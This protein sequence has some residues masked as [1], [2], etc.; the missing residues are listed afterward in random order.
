MSLE[1]LGNVS[2]GPSP[3]YHETGSL[4]EDPRPS[5]KCR[6]FESDIYLL[7][8]SKTSEYCFLGF[9]ALNYIIGEKVVNSIHL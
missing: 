1:E 6:V 5:F 3:K 2:L 4:K 8:L 7:L 9:Y